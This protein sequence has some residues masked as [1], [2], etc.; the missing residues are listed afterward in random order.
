MG[1]LTS[2]IDLLSV[3]VGDKAEIEWEISKLEGGSATAVIIGKSFN[4]EA[5]EKVVQAYEI[6]GSAI[7]KKHPIPYSYPIAKEAR[8]ITSVINGRIR[9]V[10]L[11]KEIIDYYINDDISE[12]EAEFTIGT[13]TGWV[14]TLSK[15]GRMRFILYDT[16]FDRAVNC[17]LSQDQEKFMLD[18]WDKRIS[19][20][21]KV[22]REPETGRPIEVRDINYIDIKPEI[23]PGSFF[24]V[25]GIIPWKDGDEY[26]EDIIRRL[27]DA[28]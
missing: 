28:E 16:L 24:N 2:L 10:E 14:E 15:R 19:V 22:F 7:S 9:S 8:A 23:I 1:H 21:G 25:E 5:V 20:A 27:R 12:Y 18:A 26:P 4:E 3:E 11:Q 17:Y 13:V 6:I